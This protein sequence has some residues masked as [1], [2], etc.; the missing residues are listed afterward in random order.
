M[1]PA[2]APS[3]LGAQAAVLITLRTFPS[4]Q[5]LSDQALSAPVGPKE[6][7]VQATSGCRRNMSLCFTTS[8]AAALSRSSVI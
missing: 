8:G 4:L 7:W 1:K 2:K 3:V 6:L 5:R